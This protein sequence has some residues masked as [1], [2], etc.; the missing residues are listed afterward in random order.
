MTDKYHL[1]GRIIGDK[2][3]NVEAILCRDFFKFSLTP[4]EVKKIETIKNR[5]ELDEFVKKIITD[6]QVWVW[7]DKSEIELISV[8]KE[9]F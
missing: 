1:V 3:L 8:K 2:F 5:D 4:E 6:S 7:R 9:G